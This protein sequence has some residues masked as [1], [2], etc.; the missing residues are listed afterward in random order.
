MQ[1]NIRARE[2]VGLSISAQLKALREYAERNGHVVVREFIDEAETGRS[3]S[4][5][6]AFREMII[7]ARSPAKPFEAVL[8][9]KYS[10]FAR[11]R[12]DS[13]VYKTLLRKQG[14]KVVSITEPS[15]NSPTGRLLEA[16]IE[17]MDEFYSDNLGEEVTRG[18]R[19]SVSRGFYLSSKP[20]TL[21]LDFWL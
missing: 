2:D 5:R 6:P 16:M 21:K 20:T 14:V 13:I 19:E 3:V 1:H 10:R 4:K 11:N 8:I 15:E 18:M 12:A 9:W 17:N 7:C